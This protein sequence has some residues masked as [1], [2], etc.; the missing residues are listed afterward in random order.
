MSE[1]EAI[2]EPV[3]NGPRF[4]P[5][6]FALLSL[7]LVFFLYQLIGGGLTIYLF[8]NAPTAD[9]A[10][11]FR[12]A[13]M[14]AEFIFILIPTYFLT[15]I[16]VGS[17]KEFL[18]IRKTD[19]YYVILAVV[20]VIALEQLLEVYLYFQGLIP[21]PAPLDKF[22]NQF[23]QAVEHTYK[24]LITAHSPGE[25]LFVLLVVGVTPAIC[26]ETLFRGLVQSNFEMPMSRN[27]AIIWTG[28]IFGAYHLDPFTFV[29]LCVLGIYFGYLV[30]TTGSILVPMA[31]HFT[32]NFISAFVYYESGR[33]SLIAPSVGQKVNLWYLLALS[34]LLAMIFLATL[35]LTKKHHHEIQ[36]AL[37]Q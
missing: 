11:I 3:G 25:F 33:D 23:Q 8:G 19:W 34:I 10:V 31:A 4:N 36:E 15:K 22:V 5:I 9:Q 21:V 26:E 17:W 16:Q 2:H 35:Y 7:V 24:I 13:T 29:A 32:N 27:K 37:K 1:D 20:G 6:G 30:S 14:I 12:L 18:R 28:I